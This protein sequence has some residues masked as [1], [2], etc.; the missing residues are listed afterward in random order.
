MCDRSSSQPLS[1]GR[2]LEHCGL[3]GGAEEFL[4]NFLPHF[5]FMIHTVM[6]LIYLSWVFGPRFGVNSSIQRKATAGYWLCKL[7][8][9][10]SSN[11]V[12]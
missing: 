5:T 8:P 7:F 3:G 10:Q 2:G 1:K 9:S 4:T 12:L 6:Q 11:N